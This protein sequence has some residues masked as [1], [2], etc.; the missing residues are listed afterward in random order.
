MSNY[1]STAFSGEIVSR[2]RGVIARYD[3]NQADLAAL[4]DVSQS[5]FSKIIRGV[6]PMT[7]DQFASLCDALDVDMNDLISDV[8][9]Y[10]S[11][12]SLHASPVRLVEEEDRLSK[13]EPWHRSANLDPWASAARDRVAVGGTRE[14]YD[15]VANDSIN[16]FPD[17]NDADYDHA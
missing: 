6:R 11:V 17:E 9:E 10:L 13:P 5:Q 2:L 12:R 1:E 8:T 4:C 15:L 7:L 14:D 3:I 16:E